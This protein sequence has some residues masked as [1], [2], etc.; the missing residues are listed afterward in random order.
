MEKLFLY[1]TIY[2]DS[3]DAT[4]QSKNIWVYNR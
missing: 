1:N 4:S 3:D 2:I